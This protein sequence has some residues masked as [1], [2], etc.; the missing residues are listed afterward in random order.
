MALLGEGAPPPK[1][2]I[3]GTLFQRARALG[4][5]AD[6]LMTEAESQ[7]FLEL[8]VPDSG[9]TGMVVSNDMIAAL[10]ALRREV[11]PIGAHCVA[12]YRARKVKELHL[13]NQR[14]TQQGVSRL[15]W[16]SPGATATIY[17]DLIAPRIVPR[18]AD[19]PALF[20][21]DGGTF[22]IEHGLLARLREQGAALTAIA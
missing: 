12:L 4:K 7:K 15:L 5:S 3:A 20:F 9:V 16:Q 14:L 13:F 1:V 17:L 6:V 2:T 11:G 8:M 19:G 18:L 21:L 22:L 10:L